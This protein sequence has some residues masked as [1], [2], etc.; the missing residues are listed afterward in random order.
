MLDGSLGA[1]GLMFRIRVLLSASSSESSHGDAS[2]GIISPSSPGISEHLR[3]PCALFVIESAVMHLSPLIHI[4]ILRL[5]NRSARSLYS[6]L[7][8]HAMMGAKLVENCCWRGR[9]KLS[10]MLIDKI[11]IFFP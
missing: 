7:S 9:I 1:A 4:L 11:S 8:I 5:E 10:R 6:G 2:A 3:T